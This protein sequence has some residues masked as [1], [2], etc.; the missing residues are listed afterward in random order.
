MNGSE[1]ENNG[2]IF[3]ALNSYFMTLLVKHF[4]T[5]IN[6]RIQTP[7]TY[8]KAFWENM[9]RAYVMKTSKR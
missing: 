3:S 1:K 5:K 7:A 4:F 9:P 2:K 6:F 8:A